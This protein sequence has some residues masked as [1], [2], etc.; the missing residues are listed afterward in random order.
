VWDEFI[1]NL[2][3]WM[4]ISC[5]VWGGWMLF[6]ILPYLPTELADRIIEAILG[7]LGI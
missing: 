3:K 1:K 2:M 4:T 6:S 5:Y 7:K